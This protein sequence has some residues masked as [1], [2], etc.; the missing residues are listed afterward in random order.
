[1]GDPLHQL[2]EFLCRTSFDELPASVRERARQVSAD[3]LA[4]IAGGSAE[5]EVRALTQ[6]LIPV[7][8]GG[9]SVIGTGRHGEA[10]LAAFLNATA[11][12]FLELD[13]GNQFARGH[14]GIHVVP[15][16]LAFAQL[17]GCSGRDFL[18]AV[19]LGYEVGTRIALGSVLRSSIHPHGTWGT[20]AAAVS[21]AKLAGADASEMGEVINVASP[22]GLANSD[23]TMLEGATVRNTF[24]GFS[25][26]T[27]L[28]VWNLVRSGFTGEHDGLATIW[29]K[30][31]SD[32]WCAAALTDELGQRWEI[33]RNYFKRHA[34][35]R[36]NHAALDVVV[37]LQTEHKLCADAIQLIEVETYS[38]AARLR[39]KTPK[40]TRAAKFSLPFAIATT[41]VHESS[42]LHS[43]T[44]DAIHN[45]NVTD[46]AARI[47]VSEDPIM[48]AMLPARRPARLK[49]TFVTGETLSGYTEINR[50]DWQDP[51]QQHVGGKTTRLDA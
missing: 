50:G 45:K 7:S 44:W 3:T 5:P 1:M 10:G 14:P 35:C 21:V 32:S 47:E 18:L 43:F 28:M 4:A 34:C 26:Q 13:E 12:T 15:A 41:L 39:D 29:G 51:Y 40:N 42:G 22:L 9:A 17:H 31:L 16:A 19:T 30:V 6:D 2:S 36:Y 23:Q 25:A 8:S 33:S 48:T 46:L 27:G 11:G 37:K 38:L 49:I 24:T 20:V